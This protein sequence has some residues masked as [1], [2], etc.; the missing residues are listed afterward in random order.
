MIPTEITP[1]GLAIIGSV[2]RAVPAVTFH[3]PC[4]LPAEELRSPVAISTSI[5]V[6]PLR[7]ANSNHIVLRDVEAVLIQQHRAD[8]G[9]KVPFNRSIEVRRV[10]IAN[11]APSNSAGT[12]LGPS[13]MPLRIHSRR[14]ADPA[15][16][17]LEAVAVRTNPSW[18]SAQR[19]TCHVRAFCRSSSA[20]REGMI[21]SCLR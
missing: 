3:D 18:S 7:T 13:R 1:A 17:L 6:P 2:I 20:V 8:R 9:A 10:A 14:L 5:A 15:T 16:V 12:L 4:T 19:M 21:V 11:P